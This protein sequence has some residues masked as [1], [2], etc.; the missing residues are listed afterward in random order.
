MLRTR[1]VKRGCSLLGP[2]SLLEG[3]LLEQSW[4]GETKSDLVSGQLVVAVSDGGD[5]ALHD[6][7]VKWIQEDL[8]VLLTI[9]VDSHSSS[10]DVG[11][12]ALS[13]NQQIN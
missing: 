8:L 6:L 9:K 3:L 4:L 12:E 1:D 13:V 2:L 5:L 7:L 10:G 11:W